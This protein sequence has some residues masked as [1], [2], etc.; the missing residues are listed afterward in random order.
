MQ[1]LSV[2]ATTLFSNE[3]FDMTWALRVDSHRVVILQ[4]FRQGS[5]EN[6]I[7]LVW[8]AMKQQ[9]PISEISDPF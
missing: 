4:K 6:S 3:L 5:R 7:A 2:V 9:S 1:H 8:E